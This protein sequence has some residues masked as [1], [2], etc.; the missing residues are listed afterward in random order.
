SLQFGSPRTFEPDEIALLLAVTRLFAQTHERLRLLD[1]ERQVSARARRL[2]EANIIGVM[3]ER[4]DG[5]VVEANDALL[6]LLGFTREDL[7]A[8]AIDWRRLTPPEH[9]SRTMIA[10]QEAETR[11]GSTPY[12]KEYF[13]KDGRRVP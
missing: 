2:I 7:A 5:M 8:G 13:R 4:A 10:M 11:G 3:V 1:V 6:S 9:L 12:E